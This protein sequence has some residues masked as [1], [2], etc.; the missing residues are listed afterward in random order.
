MH[1]V[2][3]KPLLAF[4]AGGRLLLVGEEMEAPKVPSRAVR[5]L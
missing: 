4:V 5:R 1:I 2:N 3:N